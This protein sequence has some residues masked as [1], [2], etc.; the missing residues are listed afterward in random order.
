VFVSRLGVGE[1]TAGTGLEL[2]AI[3]IVIIGGTSTFGGE[4]GVKGTLIGAALIMVLANILNLAGISPFIQQ[5]VKGL[6][7]IG[8]VMI[9]RQRKR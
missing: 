3:A 9:E 2:D 6:I 5:V 1:P 7:I 8:A 4:G